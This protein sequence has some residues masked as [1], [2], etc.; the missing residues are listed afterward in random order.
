M[1]PNNIY[2]VSFADGGRTIIKTFEHTNVPNR[3]LDIDYI[4]CLVIFPNGETSKCYRSTTWLLD[5]QLEDEKMYKVE[6]CTEQEFRRE[7]IKSD[8]K[9]LL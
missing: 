8:L 9:G 1:E 5:D 7:L 4:N 6:L 3:P 2:K